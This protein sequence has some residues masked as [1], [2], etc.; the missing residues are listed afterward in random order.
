[1]VEEIVA[2]E[3]ANDG[4]EIAFLKLEHLELNKLPRL[5]SFCKESFNFKFPLLETLY[6]IDCP[7]ME[8]FSH[9]I[10]STPKLRQVRV[11][12]DAD[13]EWRWEGDLNT[14]IRNWFCEK[15]AKANLETMKLSSINTKNLWDD[16]SGIQNLTHLTIDNC[17]GL[18][19]LFSASVVITLAKLKYLNVNNCQKME[20]IFVLDEELGNL[21]STMKPLTQEEVKLPNL[22]TLMVSHMDNL[23]SIYN[24]EV[25]SNPF[26]RLIKMEISFCQKLLRVFPS[27]VL[28]KLSNLETLI[29]TDCTELEVVFETQELNDEATNPGMLATMTLERLPMLKHI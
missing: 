23:K 29:V 26:P 16:I 12:P 17:G 7:K 2:S 21:Q 9:G 25:A 24:D 18:K 14:T 1:M 19:Y 15:V 8:S 3:D 6:V 22:E 11:T 20:N 5:T 28:N 27:Y 13:G 10:L 4:G